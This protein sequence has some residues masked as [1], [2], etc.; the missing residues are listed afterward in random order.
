MNRSAHP[1]YSIWRQ[2]IDRCE[3]P[4]NRKW[5]DYG[6]RGVQVCEEWHDFWTFLRDVGERPEGTYPSGRARWELDR[7][8]NDGDYEPSNVKWST[9]REQLLNRRSKITHCPRGH[10]YAETAYTNSSGW[11]ECLLCKR[12]RGAAYMRRKRSGE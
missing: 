6:G 7:I 5:E 4:R 12:E 3:N 10:D 2:M 9:R 1:M 8:D 11:R